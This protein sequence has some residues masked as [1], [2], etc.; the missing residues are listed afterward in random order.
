MS[1]LSK[2]ALLA[3]LIFVNISATGSVRLIVSTPYQLDFVTP[4]SI[5]L[6]ASERKQIRQSLNL[7]R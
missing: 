2:R 4:G 6:L 5:P 7:R 1:T 3:F